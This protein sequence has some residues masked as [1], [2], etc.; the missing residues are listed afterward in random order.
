MARYGMYAARR[1][2]ELVDPNTYNVINY[3]EADNVLNEWK[4]LADDAQK[5]YKGLDAS[6]QP[7]F[8]ELVLHPCLAGATVI[9]IHITAAKNKLYAS[10]RRTSANT[11]AEQALKLFKDDYALAQRYHELLDGKWNH[12]MDQTHLGYNYW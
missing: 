9:N 12:I 2:Y 10:Q 5:I 7:S 3:N 4:A 11:L 1:K 6:V 8:F